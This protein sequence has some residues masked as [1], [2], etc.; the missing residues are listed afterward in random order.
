MEELLEDSPALWNLTQV[1][2]QNMPSALRDVVVVVSEKPPLVSSLP[3][4]IILWAQLF[5]WEEWGVTLCKD[6]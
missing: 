1:L 2:T 5:F 3:G 6:S 4:R